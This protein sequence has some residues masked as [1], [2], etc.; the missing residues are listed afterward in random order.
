[1]TTPQP[2][3]HVPDFDAGERVVRSSLSS[4]FPKHSMYGA[5]SPACPI[6]GGGRQGASSELILCMLVANV[7]LA[8]SIGFC[9]S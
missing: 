9:A 7:Q 1:M 3:T 6:E 5:I 4:R 2:P 8:P